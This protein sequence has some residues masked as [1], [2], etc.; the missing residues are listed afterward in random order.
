MKNGPLGDDIGKY[1]ILLDKVSSTQWFALEHLRTGSAPHGTM[2]SCLEQTHGKGRLDKNWDSEKNKNIAVNFILKDFNAGASW[3]PGYLSMVAALAVCHTVKASIG[4]EVFIKWPNDIISH[5]KKIA[6]ILIT[7]QWRGIHLES[8]VIGI[9]INI[10]Q[11]N[12]RDIPHAGS[13]ISIM[14]I[15]TDV[16]MVLQ[17]L[18]KQLNYWYNILY[19]DV[20]DLVEAY[21]R[22]L[23]GYQQFIKVKTHQLDIQQDAKII[24]VDQDGKV[25]LEFENGFTG[26][27]DLDEIKIIF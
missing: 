9:G 23:Y 21:Y 27:F 14:G 16:N 19:Q 3:N 26:S 18:I 22:D 2:V 13:F 6:G 5:S 11:V 24:E 1:K 4:P 7:N 25:K 10:N 12:F 8:C 20:Q 15:E 17:T